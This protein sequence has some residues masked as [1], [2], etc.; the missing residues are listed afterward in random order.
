MRNLLGARRRAQ[1]R[2]YI[3]ELQ[4]ELA[5]ANKKIERLQ[6]ELVQGIN[7][8]NRLWVEIAKRDG[9]YKKT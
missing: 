4:A 3:A 7:E 2:E 5:A 6:G 8:R 1:Q 9:V